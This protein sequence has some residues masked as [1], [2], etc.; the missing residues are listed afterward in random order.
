[1]SPIWTA[2][3]INRFTLQAEE[4]FCNEFQCLIDRF[5]IT[6][7]SGLAQYT[8]SDNVADI[9]RITYKGKKLD[10]VSHR[11]FREFLGGLDS[12]GTPQF[13][14]FNS[15]GQQ[16]I[17]LFPT[18]TESII[19]SQTNLFSSPAIAGQCIVEFYSIPDG[20]GTKLPDYIR[21][22]LLKAYVLKQC[23]LSEGKGQN[24]KAAKYWESKWNYL[25]DTYGT[26]I[27]DLLTS[28]KKTMLP[29]GDINYGRIVEATLP[30]DRFGIGVNEGE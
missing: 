17:K 30:I 21:R 16:V 2:A 24:L 8:L 18:P 20:I 14:I 3:Q 19:A 26:Q 1:M 23:F 15:V 9:R 28:P 4:I 5:A 10:P 12:S 13:Y 27:Y 7:V 22:R 25:K 29:F 11:Q 6:I